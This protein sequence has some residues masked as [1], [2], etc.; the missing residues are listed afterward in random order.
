MEESKE[1]IS[2]IT[3]P[4]SDLDKISSSKETIIFMDFSPS[5]N[6]ILLLSSNNIIFLCSLLENIFK[7]EKKL[8]NIFNS[9]ETKIINCYFCNETKD[10]LLLLCD[11]YNIYE[12]ELNREY[13]NHIY[14]NVLGES[15]IIKMNWQKNTNPQGGIKNFCIFKENE[16]NVWN[17]LN[18]NKS[19]VL[20]DKDINCFSYDCSGIAIYFLGKRKDGYY[21]SV[22]KFINEYDCKEI[23]FKALNFIETKID[24]NYLDIFDDN[25]I[26]C[27]NKYNIYILKNYPLDKFNFIMSLNNINKQPLLFFPFIGKKE[28][29]QFGILYVNFKEGKKNILNVCYDSNKCNIVEI[30]LKVQ[31]VNYYKENN[32]GKSLLLSF[33]DIKKELKKYLL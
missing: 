32:K 24:I 9:N 2:S 33:D 31:K 10:S 18:Y 29:F 16:I 26:M 23:Y 5:N 12:Y 13:I 28:I 25:I 19:N 6:Y 17:T 11:D 22:N 30:D 15:F 8:I 4:L 1:L 20:S 27:D 14:Y 21:I 3:I 7:I